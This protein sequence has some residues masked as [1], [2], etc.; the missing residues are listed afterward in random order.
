VGG[1]VRDKLFGKAPK[2]DDYMVIATPE[3]IKRA[4]RRA[5][6][7]VA[8]LKVADRLVGVRAYHPDAPPEGVELT[9]PRIEVSTGPGH[10]DFNIVPHPALE[11]SPGEASPRRSWPNPA[12]RRRAPPLDAMLV[13][14]AQRRDFTINAMYE[15]PESGEVIDP[16]GHGIT[17]A[18][19]RILRTVNPDSF[20][21]DPLRI[22]RGLVRVS[23]DDVEP[24]AGTLDQMRE[25]AEG[26]DALSGE[27]VQG[28][29]DKLLMGANPGKAL[30]LARDTGVLPHM[31]PE[32]R[33]AVGFDQESKY[34]DLNLDEHLFSVVDKAAHANAPLE[35]RLAALFHDAGKP[36]SSW[37]GADGRLHYYAREGTRAHEDIGADMA[38]S[39]MNRLR[40]PN[41]VKDTVVHLVAAHMWGE[42]V[43]PTPLKARRFLAAHGERADM[44]IA[45]RRADMGGKDEGVPAE[46]LAKVDQFA[47][48]LR[49]EVN[50]PIRIKDLAIDG[51]D[52]I[53]KAGFTEGAILGQVLAELLH[54]VI[55]DPS[56][57]RKEWLLARARRLRRKLESR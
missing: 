14:D 51:S 33:D 4:A 6:A 25:Y 37:R 13:D 44:L 57:N 26:I 48:M 56:L 11:S 40:Y 42:F 45:L 54:D 47:E 8:D 32:L 18:E 2:D 36:A 19:Q 41:D 20:R 28:E 12:G 39:A 30:R 9:P 21:D 7:R 27:R 46:E 53:D 34:H 17:D 50:K 38:R 29:L 5:G 16:T 22:L 1:A 55:V 3:Q 23:V 52:L 15:D 31:L 43:K 35:V 49:Q 10:K 24:D